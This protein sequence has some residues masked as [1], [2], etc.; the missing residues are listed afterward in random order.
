MEAQQG[1]AKWLI[2][3]KSIRHLSP[4]PAG[5]VRCVKRENVFTRKIKT[6]GKNKLKS[7]LKPTLDYEFENHGPIVYM[8]Q[9]K[10]INRRNWKQF[11]MICRGRCFVALKVLCAPPAPPLPLLKSMIQFNHEAVD[12]WMENLVN[13]WNSIM[14][15]NFVCSQAPTAPLCEI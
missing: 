4:V 3:S 5:W 6:I 15:S 1:I 9:Y 14:R 8:N 10:L 11:E 12:E 7:S 2:L 13:N